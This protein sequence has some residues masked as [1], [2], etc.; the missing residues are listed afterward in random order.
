MSA[1]LFDPAPLI[2]Q[3]QAAADRDYFMQRC[4]DPAY[5]KCSLGTGRRYTE[6]QKAEI[7]AE[8][9]FLM[10]DGF[11]KSQVARLLRVHPQ[12]LAGILGGHPTNRRRKR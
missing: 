7:G 4:V 3:D 9:L 8:A 11:K 1:Q 5:R 6:D 2:S 10:L 12:T